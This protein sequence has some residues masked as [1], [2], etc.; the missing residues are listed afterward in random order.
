MASTEGLRRSLRGLM[1]VVS[2]DTVLLNDT[3]KANIAYGSP[4]A[5]AAQIGG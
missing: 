1:G 5:T 2:Q 4:G 3:V